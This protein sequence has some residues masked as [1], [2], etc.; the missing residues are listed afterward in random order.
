MDPCSESLQHRNNP[1]L[2][3][4][5][6]SQ[7]VD[8]ITVCRDYYQKIADQADGIEL[9]T[10]TNGTIFLYVIRNEIEGVAV[11]YLYSERSA[12]SPLWR[13]R[14]GTRLYDMICNEFEAL[15]EK[16]KPQ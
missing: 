7:I 11:P 5:M 2:E 4:L 10:V 12:E 14:Q 16:N 6:T 13:C 15:W 9:R 3:E 8:T 1:E